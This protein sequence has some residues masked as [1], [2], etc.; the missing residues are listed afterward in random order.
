MIENYLK[1]Q[2]NLSFACAMCDICS[3]YLK[4]NMGRE[5]KRERQNEGESSGRRKEGGRQR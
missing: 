1:N 4:K 3:W 2:S 5:R